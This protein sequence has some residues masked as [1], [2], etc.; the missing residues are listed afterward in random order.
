MTPEVM[1]ELM[2]GLVAIAAFAAVAFVAW[3]VLHGSN[4]EDEK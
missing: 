3:L 1:R 4:D 2:S